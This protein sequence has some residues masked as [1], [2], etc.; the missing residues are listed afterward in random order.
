MREAVTALRK[1]FDDTE[2]PAAFHHNGQTFDERCEAWLRHA[3]DRL[4]AE[5]EAFLEGQS[6]A[7]L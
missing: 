2:I 5:I 6:H 3:L 7:D 4:D 1:L